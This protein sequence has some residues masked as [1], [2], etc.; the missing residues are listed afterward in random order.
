MLPAGAL[1]GVGWCQNIIGEVPECDK[2]DGEEVDIPGITAG[3]CYSC[4]CQA[5]RVVCSS[6]RVRT[7]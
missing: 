6:R 4:H 2:Q 3:R 5:G 1:L 7:L